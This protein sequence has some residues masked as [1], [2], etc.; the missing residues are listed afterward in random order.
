MSTNNFSP[1]VIVMHKTRFLS[2]KHVYLLPVRA[3]RVRPGHLHLLTGPWSLMMDTVEEHPGCLWVSAIL[4]Y[5]THLVLLGAVLVSVAL[6]KS[7][8]S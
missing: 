8:T 1:N 6:G 2:L 7:P 3:Y 5:H 4:A